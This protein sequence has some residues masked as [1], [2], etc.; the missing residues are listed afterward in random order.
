MTTQLF[1]VAERQSEPVLVQRDDVI[2]TAVSLGTQC[3]KYTIVIFFNF[4]SFLVFFCFLDTP[5]PV[6]NYFLT[7]SGIVTH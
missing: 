6:P 2:L 3:V 7:I 4:I 5:L 1:Q